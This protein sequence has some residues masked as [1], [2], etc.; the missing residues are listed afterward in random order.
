[1]HIDMARLSGAQVVLYRLATALACGALLLRLLRVSKFETLPL[2]PVLIEK[3][4]NVTATLFVLIAFVVDIALLYYV[5][6]RMKVDF[7]ARGMNAH[8]IP[9]PGTGTSLS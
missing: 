2:V 1:M 3:A 6:R 4:I 9:G 7:M 8:T 5:G